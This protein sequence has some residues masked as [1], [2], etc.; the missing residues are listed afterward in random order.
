MVEGAEGK[1]NGGKEKKT[2]LDA[3]QGGDEVCCNAASGALRT[4]GY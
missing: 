4:D 3:M 2:K 1:G